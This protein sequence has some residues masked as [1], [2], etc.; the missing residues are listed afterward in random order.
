MSTTTNNYG[1]PT[2]DEVV[3]QYADEHGTR[4]L[5]PNGFTEWLWEFMLS[6][7]A[8]HEKMIAD[9]HAQQTWGARR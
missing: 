9:W 6:G 3:E 7:L 5:D 4:D 8:S 2:P 1:L